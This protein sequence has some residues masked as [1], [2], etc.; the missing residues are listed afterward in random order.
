ME[1]FDWLDLFFSFVLIII[2]ISPLI[3]SKAQKKS[4]GFIGLKGV[5]KSRWFGIPLIYL[6]L[7]S[8]FG[9]QNLAATITF[10]IIVSFFISLIANT[11]VYILNKRKSY[12]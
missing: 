11:L 10:S 4:T 7:F 12:Q 3:F 2:I 1:Q 8:Y 6:L 5:V 9:Y